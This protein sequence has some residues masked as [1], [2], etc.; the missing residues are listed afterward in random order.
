MTP[1]FV[2]FVMQFVLKKAKLEKFC[3]KVLETDSPQWL[4]WKRMLFFTNLLTEK[5][6]LLSTEKIVLQETFWVA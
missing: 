4:L 3:G 6:I 5:E 1:Y 2:G